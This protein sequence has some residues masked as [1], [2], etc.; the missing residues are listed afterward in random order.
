MTD[1]QILPRQT[2]IGRT[3]SQT[4]LMQ[5][6][7]TISPNKKSNLLPNIHIRSGINYP[8]HELATNEQSAP[9][10]HRDKKERKSKKHRRVREAS[11]DSPIK[12]HSTDNYYGMDQRNY[13]Q[14][15]MQE[16]PRNQHTL[17]QSDHEDYPSITPYQLPTTQS[18]NNFNNNG[19]ENNVYSNHNNNLYIENAYNN[20][21]NAHQRHNLSRESGR[22]SARI[23]EEAL[24][25]PAR[26]R[27]IISNPGLVNSNLQ[28]MRGI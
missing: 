7:P 17:R 16:Q 9:K 21:V 13:G 26:L 4:L 22:Q 20:N 28:N 12:D 10:S 25:R 18:Y 5:P 19:F 6:S 14:V 8:L 27:V 23:I 2:H 15:Y 11:H 24:A 1:V 3:S